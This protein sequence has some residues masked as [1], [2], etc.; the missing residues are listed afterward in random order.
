MRLIRKGEIYVAHFTLVGEIQDLAEQEERWTSLYLIGGGEPVGEIQSR[1]Y[2]VRIF[3]PQVLQDRQVVVLGKD[4]HA[5][6]QP[7][8]NDQN[9]EQSSKK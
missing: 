8:S 3:D 5:T 7:A 2:E 1:T 4:Y 9:D 6:Q